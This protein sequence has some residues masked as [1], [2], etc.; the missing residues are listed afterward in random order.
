MELLETTLKPQKDGNFKILL[1]K[2]YKNKSSYKKFHYNYI[3]TLSI[4]YKKTDH[5]ILFHC[6]CAKRKR[7]VTGIRFT[8]LMRNWNVHHNHRTTREDKKMSK[9]IKALLGNIWRC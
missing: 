4:L 3:I 5:E 8:E 9:K 6:F 7:S 2:T 1:Y